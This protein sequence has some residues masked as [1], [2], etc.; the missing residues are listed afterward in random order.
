[1]FLSFLPD[2]FSLYNWPTTCELCLQHI[3]SQNLHFMATL[4]NKIKFKIKFLVC[5]SFLSDMHFP[6][7]SVEDILDDKL[8]GGY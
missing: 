4:K 7:L 8:H 6:P 1:M 5:Q 2:E 3:I